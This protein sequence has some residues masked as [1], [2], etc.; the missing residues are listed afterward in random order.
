MYNTVSKWHG[1]IVAAAAAQ[2]VRSQKR[3]N[4]TVFGYI[5]VE[6]IFVE[7]IVLNAFCAFLTD[8]DQTYRLSIELFD[9][10]GTF[11]AIFAEHVLR[12]AFC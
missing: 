8:L 4:G 5:N 3:D 7:D 9:S 2:T 12:K 1:I 10:Y 11:A 6:S